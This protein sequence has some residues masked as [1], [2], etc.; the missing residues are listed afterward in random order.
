MTYGLL[1]KLTAK[2]G[3]RDEVVGIL[4]ESGKLIDDPA[5]LMYL[6]SE[7]ADDPDTIYVTDLWT[8]KE[9]H[10]EALKIPA[11]RPFIERTMPLLEGMPEQIE[12]HP[13]GGIGVPQ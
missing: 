7:A 1:N 10:A 11:L 5:C 2:P 6:V 13:V 4:L 9:Q 8:T 12:L 3:K